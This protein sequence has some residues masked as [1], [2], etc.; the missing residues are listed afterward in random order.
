MRLTENV[1]FSTGLQLT[2]QSANFLQWTQSPCCCVFVYESL[3]FFRS[4]ACDKESKT[5]KREDKPVLEKMREKN[6]YPLSF[7]GPKRRLII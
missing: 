6:E 3:A 2:G 1:I 5:I 4:L 7:Y